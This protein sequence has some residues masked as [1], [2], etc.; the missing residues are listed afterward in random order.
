MVDGPAIWNTV[1]A[2]GKVPVKTLGQQRS[3]TKWSYGDLLVAN[4]LAAG[5]GKSF[6]EI[7]ALRA[8]SKGWSVLARKLRIDPASVAARVTSATASLKR[9]KNRGMPGLRDAID[10]SDTTSFDSGAGR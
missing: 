8:G 7:K 9:G 6:E 3:S 2:G 1:S 10:R 5:S 4:S